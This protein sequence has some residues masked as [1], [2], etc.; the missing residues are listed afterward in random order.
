VN[1]N[2][3]YPPL[4]NPISSYL[5]IN[6]IRSEVGGRDTD[7]TPYEYS[8]VGFLTSLI[9]LIVLLREMRVFAQ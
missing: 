6:E 1:K 5:I 7:I 8:G 3:Y 2:N 9:L 4:Y